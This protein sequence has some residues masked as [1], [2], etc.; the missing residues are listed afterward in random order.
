MTVPA[1]WTTPDTVSGTSG[2]VASAGGSVSVSGP[3]ITVPAAN[4]EPGTAV[5]FEYESGPGPRLP[6]LVHVHRHRAVR[7]GRARQELANPPVVVVTPSG[8]TTTTPPPPPPSPPGGAGT[9]T[10]TPGRVTAAHRSTLRFTYT[11]AQAGLSPSGEVTVEVPAGWTAPS[12][13]PGQAGYVERE[14]RPAVG[15]WP[16]DHP[17]RRDPRPRAAGQH[18][19]R[20][21]D[22]PWHGQ[23]WP[24]SRPPSSRTAPRRWRPCACPRR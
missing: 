13:R 5:S 9:M 2:F 4:L 16:A 3:V 6:R 21:R 23:A 17:H 7:P 18:H 12:R 19:L 8:V 10:V 24:R 22:R 15:V 1:G 14:P 20:G 11:A